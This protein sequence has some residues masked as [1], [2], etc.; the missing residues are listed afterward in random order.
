M[1][2]GTT[3]SPNRLVSVDTPSKKRKYERTSTEGFN[4]LEKIAQANTARNQRSE[5]RGKKRKTLA[6]S[7]MPTPFQQR[8]EAAVASSVTALTNSLPNTD[9]LINGA[10]I[11]ACAVSFIGLIALSPQKTL[12]PRIGNPNALAEMVARMARESGGV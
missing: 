6:A 3:T 9:D 10:L 7:P 5:E 1:T 12:T 4:T 2:V 8:I 11:V